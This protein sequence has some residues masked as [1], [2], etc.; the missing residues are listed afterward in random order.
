MNKTKVTFYRGTLGMGIVIAVQYNKDRVIFD[1]GA[2]FSPLSEVYDGYVKERVA[3]RVTDAL[4]L[5]RIPE[6]PYVFAKK[7]LFDYPLAAYEDGDLNTAVFICHLHLDH[8][9]EMDKVHPNIPV[10]V[11]KKGLDLLEVLDHIEG[12][13]E[14][15]SY[16]PFE[17]GEK[18]QI[19]EITLT[20][21]FSDHPCPGSSSFLIETPEETVCYSGDIRYHGVNHKQAWESIDEMA[22]HNI[23]LLIVDSTT[24]SPSE[25]ALDEEFARKAKDPSRDFLPGTITEA[26][27]YEDTRNALKDY[28][29]LGIVNSYPRDTGMLEELAHIGDTIG[30]TSVFEPAYAYILWKL[31]EIRVPVY[32]PQNAR[33]SSVESE[34]SNHT[35]IS[36]EEIKVHPE[37]YIIQNSYAN[38]LNLID[39][40]G[41][42]GKYFHLFGEPLVE[43]QKHYQILKNMLAKLGWEFRSYLNLYSFS[44]AYP[45]HLSEVVR[46]LDPKCVVAVHSK[47]PENLNPV[48]AKQYFPIE[49]KEYVLK[50]GALKED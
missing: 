23:D 20:P 16:T 5:G 10:Y 6:V 14:P 42:S 48:N 45:N 30:R 21:F 9:S 3:H 49:G 22:K 46:T 31:K 34:L 26:D 37:K 40:D 47:H 19:G 13:K 50:N 8:M 15:R 39:F 11:H 44:H 1:F 25:F 43:G 2:P 28:K 38:I 4:N 36:V 17:Y 12:K 18:I 35:W 33:D 32:W 27:I 24:T 41:I 29:G 7:D